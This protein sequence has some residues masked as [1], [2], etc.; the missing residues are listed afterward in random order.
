MK[1]KVF[2]VGLSR[3]G[4]VSL[5][6]ALKRLGYRAK[7]YPDL[8]QVIELSKR[9]DALTDTPVIVFMEAL[10]RLWPEARFVLTVREEESWIRSLRRHYA[11]KPPAQIMKWKLWNR[12]CVYEVHTFDEAR[13]RR[14]RREHEIRVRALFAGRSGKLLV[15]NVCG[16]EGYETLCPFLGKPLVRE[17]FP[18]QN[19]G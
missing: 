4:T 8:F 3:T 18:H 6:T 17:P 9:F 16:G 11:K 2:G 5:T 12:R 14:I 10:D 7:H 1:E 19:K 15:L 13:M